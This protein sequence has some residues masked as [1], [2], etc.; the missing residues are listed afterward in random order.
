[1]SHVWLLDVAL[2]TFAISLKLIC[3]AKVPYVSTDL[4]LDLHHLC[5]FSPQMTVASVG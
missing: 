4:K 3:Y 2:I 1:M 5:I